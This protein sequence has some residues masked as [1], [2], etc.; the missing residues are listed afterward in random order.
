MKWFSNLKLRT[1][2]VICFVIL[3]VFTGIIGFMGISNMG[4]INSRG[5]DMY[6][7]NFVPS[8]S[9]SKIQRA[10]LIIRSD[11][12][13]MVYEKD[14]AKFQE[15]YDEINSFAEETNN[16]MQ[17]YEKTIGT[18]KT[19]KDLFEALKTN[20][21]AYRTIRSAHLDIVKAGKY[22]E[23]ITKLPEFT[24]AR[25]QVE[26]S[27]N[28]LVKYNTENALGKANEN[29]KDYQ[30]Q[31]I[32]MIAIIIAGIVLS[33][34][35]GLVIAGIISRPLNKLVVSANHI[36]DGNL[37]VSIEA[38]TEDE[39]GILAKA[40]TK[41][42]D[43]LNDVMSNIN[44]AAEQ[45]A[46][47]SRQVSDSSM[48]LS[49]GATEQASSVEELTASLEEIASQTRLN[50]DNANQANSLAVTAKGNAVQ[51][52]DQM[53][54]MLNA[55]EEINESS[56]NIYKII[57][58]I[59]DIAFQTNILA[60]NAAVE[61]ARAG[62][63]G[64]GFAVVAEEVRNLA[65]RSANAAKETTDMIE[66]S[67][68]KV[69]GGTKIAN[70]TAEALNKIVEDVT[71]VASLVSNIAVASS[72]Q[73][74]G[75]AQVNQ[76]IMQVSEVVQTNSA[77]SEESA[78]ASEELSSQ[79]ELLKE[80]VSRFRLRKTNTAVHGY[81]SMDDLNPDIIR[82]LDQMNSRKT[83]AAGNE[84]HNESTPAAASRKIVLSDREFGKY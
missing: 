82:L 70:Q 24:A 40:F 34:G 78:A 52:N 57:K 45:V 72:E 14:A 10:M 65:A 49:Q 62:Q 64:K 54:E 44:I 47:G 53:K 18:D 67:I 81:K 23:A 83:P 74:S 46:S 73:A 79:A 39:V 68:K 41:M 6:Y 58:V 26:N 56:S 22:E 60:L 63:H 76:G 29:T 35:L 36:A 27:I 33:I 69:E 31:S 4:T 71:K 16:I 84:P 43:N 28:D 59:D 51:G 12:L 15:R 7:N 8:T 55:M 25:V 80:Q 19:N 1:K 75:I 48:A 61:A 5:D 20:L 42:T 50:A 66:G 38:T 30:S 2:L 21:A 77:T 17:E 32:I 3:A 11:Y 9:L 13:L 37:D